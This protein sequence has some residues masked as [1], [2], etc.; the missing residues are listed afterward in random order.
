MRA[1]TRRNRTAPFADRQRAQCDLE[2]ASELPRDLAR[3]GIVEPKL[4]KKGV[5][6]FACRRRPVAVQSHQGRLHV[7]VETFTAPLWIEIN[8]GK[9]VARFDTEI[10]RVRVEIA[11]QLRVG[12]FGDRRRILGK[13]LQLRH[14]PAADDRVLP[15]EAHRDRFT[16]VDL[17]ANGLL[18]HAVELQ[19]RRHA[20]MDRIEARG[21]LLDAPLR[22]DD[23]I[24]RG[25]AIAEPVISEEQREAEHR[26]V[27]Q[28]FAQP[29]REGILAGGGGVRGGLLQSD[30]HMYD[31]PRR[32]K[33]RALL[34]GA[35]ID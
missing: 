22:D 23:A 28:R 19:R 33:R 9:A 24:A 25:Y 21:E 15:V 18:D 10:R 30:G 2:I 16:R 5:A 11:L 6:E 12:R 27:Q 8:V 26:E 29:A 32:E 1:E 17:L 7:R 14:E 13:K 4:E 31:N 35:R 20:L 3:R 34:R